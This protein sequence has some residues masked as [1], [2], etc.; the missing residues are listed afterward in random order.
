[1]SNRAAFLETVKGEFRFCDADLAEPGE[2]EVLVKVH[3]CAI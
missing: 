1:M 3:A 2:G